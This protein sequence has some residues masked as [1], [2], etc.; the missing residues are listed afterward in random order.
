MKVNRLE[1][2]D[3]FES[4]TKDTFEIGATCQ[5]MIESKPFGGH[6]FYI[7]AHTR[8]MEDAATKRLIWQPRLTKPLPE[9]NSM[10]FKGYPNTDLVKIMW[11]IPAPELWSQYEKGKITH[12]ALVLECIEKF[13][14]NIEELKKKEDDDLSDEQID[15]IYREISEEANRK[16][17]VV[18]E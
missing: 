8:T 12:N 7:F 17:R 10:L 1:A 13:K 15:Q 16:K 6:A 3:R 11:M 5:K 14:N 2:H 4:V 9:T 18:S